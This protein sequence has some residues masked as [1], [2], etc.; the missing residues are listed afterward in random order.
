MGKHN[1]SVEEREGVSAEF[2]SGEIRVVIVLRENVLRMM[3]EC[4]ENELEFNRLLELISKASVS[5][6]FEVINSN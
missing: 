2:N 5:E 6:L 1:I 4:S 3:R